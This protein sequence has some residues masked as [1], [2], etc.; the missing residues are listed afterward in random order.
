MRRPRR[1]VTVVDVASAAGVSPG[2]VSNAISGKRKVDQD[3]RARINRAILDL[4]YVPNL[5]ARGMRTGRTNTIAVFSSMPTAVAAGSARLG[6]LMEIAA[7]AAVTALEHNM[8]L[9]LVPPIREASKALSSVP[10]D[11]MLMIEPEEDDANLACLRQRGTPTMVIGLRDG[12]PGPGVMMDFRRMAELLISHLLETGVRHMPL[13]LGQSTRQ[14][15]LF[16]RQTYERMMAQAGL[17]A[18]VHVVPE[19]DAERGASA[20]I[21]QD[22]T[23][24]LP[25]DGVLAPIDAMAAG[26]MAALRQ[27]GLSVPGDVK[28]ATRYD[29]FR[30]RSETPPL[31]ALNL[32]LDEV[33]Q[34]ATAGLIGAIETGGAPILTGP[35][36]RLVVRSSTVG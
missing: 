12:A 32:R 13:I 4:G 1:R 21:L 33:A 2:T 15:N 28:V 3:T 9:V 17:A 19:A 16:F 36:P 14:S 5:A 31:T 29:G 30:A 35:E 18:R 11:G 23:A 24:G 10:F 26:T 34:I 20:A 22:I 25:I 27:A 7:S 8:A 6:F